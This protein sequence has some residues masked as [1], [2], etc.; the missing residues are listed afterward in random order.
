MSLS[1]VEQAGSI[2]YSRL[3][4]S[5]A[6]GS[7]MY[8]RGAAHSSVESVLIEQKGELRRTLRNQLFLHASG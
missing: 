4:T 7:L 1:G 6:F 3:L 8:L 2:I 5:L